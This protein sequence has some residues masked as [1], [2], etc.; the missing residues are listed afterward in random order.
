MNGRQLIES[1]IPTILNER[2]HVWRACKLFCDS[3]GNHKGFACSI[4]SRV[5][6]DHMDRELYKA[7]VQIG[8]LPEEK[9]DGN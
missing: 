2:Q 7:I 6:D 9:N 4:C 8:F 1:K 3:C 5:V